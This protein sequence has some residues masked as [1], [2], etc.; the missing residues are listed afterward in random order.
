LALL[1]DVALDLA[2]PAGAVLTITPGE[3]AAVEQSKGDFRAGRTVTSEQYQ[4]E[5]ATFLCDLKAKYP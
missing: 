3:R 4:A 1:A 2:E 5:M